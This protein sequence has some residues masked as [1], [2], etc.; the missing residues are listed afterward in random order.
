MRSDSFRH[1]LIWSV[2]LMS[3]FGATV[4]A[5]GLSITKTDLPDPVVAGTDLTYTITATNDG[6]GDTPDVEI[7]DPLPPGTTFVSA[8]PSAGGACT[9]P[10]VGGTGT[11][12]CTWAGATG[13]GVSRTVTLVVHVDPGVPAGSTITNVATVVSSVLAADASADTLVINQ[14]NLAVTKDDLPDP[15]VAGEDLTYSITATNSGPSV[16]PDVE[17]SD[18][19]PLNTT[20]VSATPSAGGACTTPPVGGAGTVSCTWAGTTSVGVVRSLTLV[21]RVELTAADGSTITNTAVATPS[22]LANDATADT[23]V[24]NQ[25]DLSITKDDG[26]TTAVPG[27][28]TT[29]TI[30]VEN[31]AGSAP[32]TAFVPPNDPTGMVFSTGSNNGYVG[33][34][35]VVFE[36]L[37]TTTVS[38]VGLFHDLT[39]VNLS[40]EVAEVTSLVGLVTSGQ[41]VLRSGSTLVTTSGLEF[42]DVAIVP[43][44]LTVG[45]FYHIEFSHVGPANQN[46]FY[47][48]SNV[49]FDQG[50][51]A[52]IEGSQGGNT[53]NFVMPAIRVG[54]GGSGGSDVVGATVTDVFGPE[55]DCTWTCT[56]SG[57]ASCTAG[58]VVGHIIDTVDIPVGD[59]VTYTAVCAVH[60]SALG[61]LVNN[62]FV[63][64]PAGVTDPNSSN[65]LSFDTDTLTPVADLSVTKDDSRDPAAAG[66]P[67]SYTVTVDNAGPSD[68]RTVAVTD[69]LPAGV[70]FA[71][72][73]GC[74]NDPNGVPVCD[75]S[76]IPAGGSEAYTIDVDVD[77][78]TPS[79]T[80]TNS[81]SVASA[82][83]DPDPSDDSDA[84]DTLVDADPPIVTLVNSSA[85]TGDGVLEECEEAKVQITLLRVSFNEPVQ[86]PAGSS[87]PSDVTNP[88]NYQLLAAGPDGD[89]STVVCGPPLG[90]DLPVG[91]DSVT[92]DAGSLTATID[93][94]AQLLDSLYR[95]LVCGSTS[96]RDI[97]GNALDGNADGVRGDDFLR[98]YRIDR[99]NRFVGGHFDCEI[100]PWVTVS[101]DPAEIG[102]SPDDV[103]A[104]SVSGSA[105]VVNLTASTDFSLG[106][107]PAAEGSTSYT[108]SGRL[109][110]SAAPDVR[111]FV[112][113]TCEFFSAPSCAGPS[114]LTE[115]EFAFLGDSGGDWQELTSELIAPAG[116][117]SALCS[118][119]LDAPGGVDFD[120]RFD[121][122]SL[123]RSSRIFAD[124]FESGDTLAWSSSTP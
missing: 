14:V 3:T 24:I 9:T 35:G 38:S 25:A 107:C 92:W 48:N 52:S 43:L 19:L 64:A 23:L 49:A 84:E 74:L 93:P 104:S 100:D 81:V 97:A 36:A 50:D 55:L 124:G 12:T 80:I 20:F 87:G 86:D 120:A 5:S 8:T 119:D 46:F 122:L 71:S 57:G 42:I 18:S 37:S 21:V 22:V 75:L 95:L 99:A 4:V 117:A 116:S 40:F 44:T 85:D 76:T 30:T 15:V 41:T 33:G 45:S 34:R 67:L 83:D 101:T 98:T 103:Q 2:L 110:L 62:A 16:A 102:Y 26:T 88:A 79:G 114:L 56:P 115:T 47:D 112:T 121:D 109:R 60:R 118:F 73:S 13:A 17:I 77:A 61:S 6:P 10:P 111:L 69:T 90:D 63:S 70:S 32:S 53:S 54:T 31:A 27:T 96:I 66:D 72:T 28:S 89:F 108:L 94:T 113:R 106:Q 78:A 39:G 123:A 65:N 7:S 91:I 51:F 29:Y 105:E 68:A 82:A 1:L 11:V 59:S 58:P